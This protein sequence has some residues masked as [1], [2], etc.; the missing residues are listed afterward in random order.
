MGLRVSRWL[1]WTLALL[2]LGG[3][4]YP[5]RE[6]VDR[7][8]CDLAAHPL[9]LQPDFA[10]D[11]PPA[12]MPPAQDT[13]AP[14][15]PATTPSA[16]LPA[17]SP[18]DAGVRPAAAQEP[19]EREPTPPRPRIS[20]AE[21]L[22]IPADLPGA[23]APDLPVLP[24]SSRENNKPREEAIRRL[25]PPLPPLGRDPQPV[26][27]PDGHP[28]S[29]SDLQALALTNSPLIHQAAAQAK[30]AE[31]AAIQA[32]AYPN[33]NFGYQ[34]DT[35]GTSA[36][37]GF[38]GIFLEQLIKTAGKLKLAEA[39]ATMDLLN[40]R[41][42]LRKAQADLATQVR[43]GYFA[44]LVA[45]ENM[46]VS[47]ALV[48]IA[49]QVY[50]IQLAQLRVGVA[51]NYEPMQLQVL[52]MQARAALVLARYRYVS[53]WKQLAAALGLPAL[54]PTELAGRVDMDIPVFRYD[55]VLTRT[56]SNHTDVL[57]ALNGI[58]KAR[59]N[60][61]LAQVTPIPDVML[62]LA[63]E[64]DF[65]MPPFAITHSIQL[66]VPVPLWDQNRG[67]I[68]QAQ[69]NLY[70]AMDDPHRVRDDLT[71]RLADAF[72]R[73]A[74]NLVLVDYYRLRILPDQIRVYRAVLER[75]QDEPDRVSFGDIVTA[76]QTLATAIT[77]Y[78]STLG[79]LWQAVADVGG[80]LQTNDLFQM[81]PEALPRQC[82]S[83]APELDQLLPLPCAHP[84]SP[85][86]DPTLK[87]ADG[88][89]PAAQGTAVTPQ[90]PPAENGN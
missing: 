17:S 49:D 10:A 41:L 89:W 37:A 45:Q 80:L 76:Q 74:D 28:L 57:T 59:Y 15:P 68:I 6:Q 5:V 2:L 30:A 44:V 25:Y 8:V 66:G 58:M 65:S 84:C 16:G 12:T 4:C 36:T 85:L 67:N 3:C 62:H 33:P 48:T 70:S 88:H 9:D 18:I 78:V 71:T 31:G 19:A 38:Q 34:S 43:S 87:G 29:L 22:K 83:S 77:T 86:P 1:P 7:A 35:A 39:A 61:R 11:R 40:A 13:Q 55:D 69:A 73:Y 42:S 47:R 90:M 56:L 23:R 53:A 79:A 14:G 20:F 63:I 21:L 27:G 26:P 82:V 51:A 75:H 64:K 24:R 60:L 32:G 52:S 81:G 54:P 46:R 50:A 72:E